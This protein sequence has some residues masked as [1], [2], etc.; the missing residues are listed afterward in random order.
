MAFHDANDIV[1]GFVGEGNVG[2]PRAV[3]DCSAWFVG[4]RLTRKGPFWLFC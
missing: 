2:V 3:S 4:W 1:A